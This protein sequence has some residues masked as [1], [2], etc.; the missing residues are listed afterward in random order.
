MRDVSKFRD[1]LMLL[2][3]NSRADLLK[4]LAF[5]M[6]DDRTRNKILRESKDGTVTSYM[7]GALRNVR[8]QAARPST[9]GRGY[10]AHG[11]DR[12]PARQESHVARL[13]ADCERWGM[14]AAYTRGAF[15]SK[16]LEQLSPDSQAEL[17]LALGNKLRDETQ[18]ES[19]KSTSKDGTITH[20]VL[21]ALKMSME[22]EKRRVSTKSQASATHANAFGNNAARNPPAGANREEPRAK[23]QK[24]LGPYAYIQE[25]R[26]RQAAQRRAAEEAAQCS[27]ETLALGQQLKEKNSQ[28]DER[29]K[30]TSDPRVT[31]NADGRV[32][33]TEKFSER[34]K[35]WYIVN[36]L[37]PEQ[38]QWV[39][40][41]QG[42]QIMKGSAADAK[43]AAEDEE[44]KRLAGAIDAGCSSM[45]NTV[46]ENPA[47]EAEQNVTQQQVGEA[48]KVDGLE[49]QKAQQ[50]AQEAEA[51]EAQAREQIAVLERRLE[52]EKVAKQQALE[53][54]EMQQ[55]KRD[56]QAAKQPEEARLAEKQQKREH[57]EPAAEKKREKSEKDAHAQKRR[58][59]L[60]STDQESGAADD[61]V[62]EDASRQH[63]IPIAPWKR[64]ER[65]AQAAAEQA[66][67]RAAILES[68]L[69]ATR[70]ELEEKRHWQ[71]SRHLPSEQDVQQQQADTL[72]TN[73]LQSVSLHSNACTGDS[74]E[75]GNLEGQVTKFLQAQGGSAYLHEVGAHLGRS[76]KHAGGMKA[77]CEAR[78]DRYVMVDEGQGRLLVTLRSE[79]PKVIRIGCK[80]AR[81][82]GAGA[83]A[84]AGAVAA[85]A[86][87]AAAAAVA[88]EDEWLSGHTCSFSPCAAFITPRGSGHDGDYYCHRAVAG[89][90]FLR[91]GTPV[92]F[93][94]K[95]SKHPKYEVEVGRLRKPKNSA[96]TL[97]VYR[98]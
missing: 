43:K 97:L 32:G 93:T 41:E 27:T 39:T 91:E 59:D 70:R 47:R 34:K 5:K 37:K 66:I 8:E 42:G 62:P 31:A 40:F 36:L 21:D 49:A 61:A 74:L 87:A 30:M 16:G 78:A 46:G 26:D 19:I 88:Q 71:D 67:Q 14:N 50:A 33:W 24:V 65:L 17:I 44:R 4:D 20:F 86:A 72:Q 2:S 6:R 79:Q 11:G 28:A 83:G 95:R 38:R 92:E 96:S 7:F 22:E 18:R 76:L 98:R 29:R 25:Q 52:E 84:G 56:V 55:R 81:T 58:K 12:T 45:A 1:G 77:W 9:F 90:D 64:P 94:L 3:P 10:A 53:A 57:T 48:R 89:F 82:A 75:I 15:L 85:A 63:M 13:L 54:A 23:K 60:H 69:A 73:A 80:R 51:R 35:T 68:E